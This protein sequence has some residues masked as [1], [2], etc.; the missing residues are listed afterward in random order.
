MGAD[1]LKKVNIY[2]NASV[3]R[4]ILA[5]LLLISTTMGCTSS[6]A[7]ERDART[8]QIFSYLLA[9]L[10]KGYYSCLLFPVSLLR[11]IYI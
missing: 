1:G 9:M 6:K 3:L 4:A 8:R 7:Q 10:P 2:L 11:V 5:I